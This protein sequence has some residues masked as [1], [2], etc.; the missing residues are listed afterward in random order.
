MI[1][2]TVGTQLPFD[3]LADKVYEWC[4]INEV[5]FILQV[6]ES[7]IASDI[8]G[9]FRY[10][11]PHKFKAAFEKCDLVISHAGMGTILTCAKHK[12]PLLVVPRDHR[13]GEHRNAHQRAT[14]N[15]LSK[16][17][18]GIVCDNENDLIVKLNCGD[19]KYPIFDSYLSRSFGLNLL[20][21]INK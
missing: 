17:L 18:E 9:V 4:K 21:V 5:E 8:H 15:A 14:V 12:K 19:F 2:L 16:S 13:L 3:R 7:N 10:L 1:F 11:E 20:E 6:G